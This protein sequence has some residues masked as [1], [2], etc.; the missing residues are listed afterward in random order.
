MSD[1]RHAR[2]R[3]TR[4][5]V[6]ADLGVNFVERQILLA[7]FSADRFFSDYGIDLEVGTFSDSGDVEPGEIKFQVKSSDA[8]QRSADGS[9]IS[10]RVSAANFRVWL[11]EW[12]PVILAFY[13]VPRDCAYWLDVQEHARLNE[14]DEDVGGE[15]LTLRVPTAQVVSRVAVLGWREL[16]R[17]V[18]LRK[19]NAD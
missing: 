17:A 11:M 1:G 5:H 10:V 7:G 9:F 18:S 16:T 8:P 12:A 3:R 13:D 19:R 14:L 15:T 6:I 4:E 2:K